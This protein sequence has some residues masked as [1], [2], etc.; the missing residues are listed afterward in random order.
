MDFDTLASYKLN[1]F[2]YAITTAAAYQSKPPPN[3]ERVAEEGDYVLWRRVAETP[4]SRILEEEN[5]GPGNPGSALDCTIAGGP[6][7]RAGEAT[8]LPSPVL[9][10]PEA[11][12]G[13]D[14]VEDAA[15]GQENAF[16]APATATQTLDLPPG[17][18]ALSVQYH[19]QAEL[20]IGPA[21]RMTSFELPPSL[22]GM[23]LTSPGRGAFWPAGAI[24]VMPGQGRVRIEVTA[25][26]PTDLQD[27]LGVERRVWL[28]ALAAA[29]EPLD[30]TDELQIGD[31]CGEYVDRFTLR[32]PGRDG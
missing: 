18:W 24:E 15:G 17:T 9:S 27:A 12:K 20:R 19:S 1:Q 10:A 25:A 4:R 2:D 8:V 29:P 31:A 21:D 13:T 28:G 3:M 14:R 32:R 22:D 26:E 23:Y 6:G 11:W 16:L 7:E 5:S 30:A